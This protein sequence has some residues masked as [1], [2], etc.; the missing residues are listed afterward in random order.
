MPPGFHSHGAN[1]NDFCSLLWGAT[2]EA[3]VLLGQ[4]FHAQSYKLKICLRLGY[5]LSDEKLGLF[6]L[7]Q[8][9]GTL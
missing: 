5:H 3:H 6:I 1:E 2:I 9:L 8:L 4:R 7:L